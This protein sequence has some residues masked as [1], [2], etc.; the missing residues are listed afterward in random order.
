MWV[1][2][3]LSQEPYRHLLSASISTHSTSFKFCHELLW[4]SCETAQPWAWGQRDEIRLIRA[5]IPHLCSLMKAGIDL[6][7]ASIRE[8]GCPGQPYSSFC[9][10]FLSVL[11]LF[12][13]MQNKQIFL[14]LPVLCAF[15]ILQLF[16][17]F[18]WCPLHCS[19]STIVRIANVSGS[20]IGSPVL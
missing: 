9:Q 2:M 11:F 3:P 1:G 17:T 13:I 6:L 20:F 4:S 10:F 7:Y 12:K 8:G 18:R 15:M 14:L 19:C 5:C 16:A